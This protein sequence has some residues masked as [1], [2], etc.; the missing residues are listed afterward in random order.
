MKMKMKMKMMASVRAPG[1]DRHWPRS[2][3][4]AIPPPDLVTAA[5]RHILKCA[6]LL[7]PAMASLKSFLLL[8]LAL[9]VTLTPAWSADEA[10]KAWSS[11]LSASAQRN[12]DGTQVDLTVPQ[13]PEEWE[14]NPPKDKSVV[15]DRVRAETERLL[16]VAEQARSFAAKYPEDPRRPS[17]RQIAAR[18]LASAERLGSPTARAQLAALDG[19]RLSDPKL[20]PSERLEIRMRQVQSEA[21]A[22]MRKSPE[23]ARDNFEQGARTLISEFPQ[24]PA[25]WAMLMEVIDQGNDPATRQKLK[26]IIA[27]GAPTAIKER[28]AGVLRRYDALNK[29][30]D[31]KFTALDGR[32]V[33]TAAMRGKVVIIHFWATWCEPCV[34]AIEKMTRAY[35]GLKELGVEMI[36]IDLD[37][38]KE[39]VEK[40]VKE[41]G[42]AWPQ[43]WD[44][45]GKNNRIVREWGVTIFPAMWLIDKNGV[46]RDLTGQTD[47]MKK[48][49]GLLG[50]TAARPEKK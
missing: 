50:E 1:V 39:N 13:L 41:K 12:I 27:G 47:L 46:L 16:A 4:L 17:A 37:A 7:L 45:E 40:F 3:C 24:E 32:Q 34:E 31:L 10:D 2:D 19:E 38:K 5:A 43:F 48:I 44:A 35:A 23:E 22:I 11:V 8:L 14:K 29:P 36:G 18:A 49:E 30:F 15:L 21:E 25:P 33:D 9:V 42:V 26:E 6:S 28:A 20:P